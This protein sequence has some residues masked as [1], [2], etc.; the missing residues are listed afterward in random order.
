MRR[1]ARRAGAI[2]AGLYAILLGLGACQRAADDRT[3]GER[4]DAAGAVVANTSEGDLP[5]WLAPTDGTDPGRRNTARRE[6][7]GISRGN[8]WPCRLRT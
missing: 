7:R 5:A 3:E 8:R 4:D 6:T 2:P 1:A